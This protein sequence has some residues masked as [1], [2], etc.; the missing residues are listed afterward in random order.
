MLITSGALFSGPQVLFQDK[1]SSSMFVLVF[2]QHLK[3]NSPRLSCDSMFCLEA[4]RNVK[5]K[6]NTP[7][8]LELRS[9]TKVLISLVPIH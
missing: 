7:H 1:D 8:H 6:N 4:G 9:W 5:R 3:P 2:H